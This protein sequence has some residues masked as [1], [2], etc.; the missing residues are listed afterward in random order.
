MAEDRADSL[1]RRST[2]SGWI[3]CRSGN[4]VFLGWYDR[5]WPDSDLAQRSI[6]HDVSILHCT[7][8]NQNLTRPPEN[9]DA[10]LNDPG[11]EFSTD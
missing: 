5:S 6:L 3:T 8:R 10:P 1:Q 7:T 11:F 4:S 2:G 9:P